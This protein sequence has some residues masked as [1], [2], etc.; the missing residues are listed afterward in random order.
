MGTWRFGPFELHSAG[1]QLLRDGVEVDLQPL[2]FRLLEYAA[3]RPGTLLTR[4]ALEQHLWPDVSV[5]EHSLTQ[6]AHRVRVALGEHRAWWRTV[7]RRGFRFEAPVSVEH[8]TAPTAGGDFVGRAAE[9]RQ[10]ADALDASRLVTV[11][12]PGGSGKTRLVRVLAAGIDAVFCDLVPARTRGE[13]LT[14][15]A[16]ALGA[17]PAGEVIDA[18]GVALAARGPVTLV[19]DNFEQVHAEAG[20]IPELLERAPAVRVLVT[21]RRALGLAGEWVVPLSGLP[22]EE[23]V[24]LLRVRARS[25]GCEPNDDADLLPLVRRLDG[26]PLAIELVAPR[27]SLLTPEQILARVDRASRDPARVDRHASVDAALRA[28]WDLL[29]EVERAA[30]VQATVFAREFDLDAA[31]AV[32]ETGDAW[33][34]DVLQRLVGHSLVETRDGPRRLVLLETVRRWAGARRA[35]EVDRRH[36]RYYA[37]LANSR[38]LD[39]D[40]AVQLVAACRRAVERA[41]TELAQVTAR[42]VAEIAQRARSP[43]PGVLPLVRAALALGPDRGLALAAARLQGVQGDPAGARAHLEDLAEADPPDAIAATA[44]ASAGWMLHKLGRPREALTRLDTAVEQLTALGEQRTLARALRIRSDSRHLL[45]DLDGAHA[46]LDA[47]ARIHADLGAD[48]PWVQ[49]ARAHLRLLAGRAAEAALLAQALLD[50][51]DTRRDRRLWAYTLMTLAT[52]RPD[53]DAKVRD[54]R[55]ALALYR[56]LGCIYH[57]AYGQLTLG[58]ALGAVD[59][60]D[61]ALVALREATAIADRASYDGVLADCYQL[62]AQAHLD[63]GRLEQAEEL[64]RSA[65]ALHDAL[66]NEAES[67]R[68]RRL[69]AAVGRAGESP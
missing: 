60:W 56:E 31:E 9:L 47:V 13:V 22:D 27:L 64:V 53:S 62:T 15:V 39:A 40:E 4:K 18:L 42:P 66:G 43:L 33:V 35:V 54:L 14:A 12:G 29:D 7:P 11:R 23:A 46:D 44:S 48:D 20:V 57:L 26:L 10:I 28:S 45:G 37:E 36:G 58:R 59:R 50:R 61:E 19:L 21:S 17:E 30:L 63:G 34:V 51:P 67:A 3:A 55:A 2:V 38:P 68:D 24:T 65:Q 6:A 8:P 32:V 69:L 49:A 52:A 25:A 41:D 5:T 1:G 16:A